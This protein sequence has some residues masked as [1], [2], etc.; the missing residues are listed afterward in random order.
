MSKQLREITTEE[1]I[2]VAKF[3]D[4]DYSKPYEH[5]IKHEPD[6][7]WIY[8]GIGCIASTIEIVFHPFHIKTRF[9]GPPRQARGIEHIRVY[10]KLCE[11][12][13]KEAINIW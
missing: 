6:R 2:E 10:V 13:Y 11:F 4:S 5:T 9:E 1:A 7:L 12:G 8:P 3:V